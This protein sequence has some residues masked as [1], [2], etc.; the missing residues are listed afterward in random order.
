VLS[1]DMFENG[2]AGALKLD[3]G[4]FS[5]RGEMKRL[6]ILKATECKK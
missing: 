4:E 1:F 6:E 3:F 5:L 2:V